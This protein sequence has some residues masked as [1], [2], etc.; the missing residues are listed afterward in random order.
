MTYTVI[1]KRPRSGKT[2]NILTASDDVTISQK[3]AEE[4]IQKH[5]A[6]KGWRYYGHSE[7]TSHE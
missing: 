3:Q 7:N 2:L 1:F 5:H 6:N 4:Y